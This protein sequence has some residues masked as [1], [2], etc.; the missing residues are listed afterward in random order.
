MI[1]SI[2]VKGFK[3]LADFNF[4]LSKF[5]CLIGMNGAGK[6]TVLQVMDFIVQLM[7]GNVDEWLARREWT[8][9]ELN[10]KFQPNDYFIGLSIEY[11]TNNDDEIFWYGVFNRRRLLCSTEGILV[12]NIEQLKVNRKLYRIGE[13]PH[14]SITPIAFNYQGSILSQLRDSE[15]PAPILEFRNHIRRIKSLE[16]LAPSLLRKRA[17]TTDKDIGT[18]GEKL[19]AFL[20]GI[21]GES[22]IALIALL[23]EFYPNLIDYKVSSQK[24]GWKKLTIIEQFG[25]RKLETEAR[26]INDG[27]LRILAILAQSS[28]DHS[29]ILLDEIENGINPE[30]VEKLVD[31]L[32]NSKQQILVTTHSPMILNYLED[33][34]ARDS[35]QF[36]YKNDKGETKARP[37]FSIPRI[38][39]KL[40][41]MGAG[42]AFVDTDLIALT[43][44]C[45][46]LD[47]KEL[48]EKEQTK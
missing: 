14:G 8:T 20:H 2:G 15:I 6:S 16:L 35:V 1:K 12:N 44:E 37:F 46:A 45:V 33:E 43:Q 36:I 7:E 17:R 32:V 31:T 21:K 10:N 3:S 22:R 23:K 38:G 5:N 18:G 13:K 24:S 25:E 4:D 48:E 42:E 40:D 29:L 39:E 47:V 11:Q 9:F 28:S 26:H 34:V 30:I 27:L 41:Y 19:S